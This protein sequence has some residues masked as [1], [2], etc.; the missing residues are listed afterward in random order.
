MC[1]VKRVLSVLVLS[2]LLVNP[3]YVNA[4]A[5]SNDSTV[6]DEQ[7]SNLPSEIVISKS[8]DDNTSVSSLYKSTFY[9]HSNC[10]IITAS[11]IYNEESELSVKDYTDVN[12]LRGFS[13]SVN[14]QGKYMIQAEDSMGH[15]YDKTLNYG[16]AIVDKTK[17]V[18]KY[19]KVVLSSKKVKKFNVKT[20][21]VVTDVGSGL[22][23]IKIGSKTYD[24][25]GKK[26]FSA[27]IGNGTYTVKACDTQGNIQKGKIAIDTK[28][29]SYTLGRVGY[30]SLTFIDSNGIKKVNAPGLRVLW[31]ENLAYVKIDP[32]DMTKYNITV[33]DTFGN[34]LK[35]TYYNGKVKKKK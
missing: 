34:K 26:I 2:A 23:Y 32:T 25:S 15:V 6:V 1:N 17:P 8:K 22:D 21:V 5:P 24:C 13:F 29:P 31:G 20:Q 12:G 16:S 35:V 30:Y 9:I 18:I 28:K 11:V 33:I 27:S 19:N 7:E 14:K 3:I 4:D 10:D